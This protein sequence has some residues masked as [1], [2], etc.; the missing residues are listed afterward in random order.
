MATKQNSVNNL[1]TSGVFTTG[2]TAGNTALI[3]AYDVDGA[4]P[5]T[6]ATLTANNTPTMDLSD[7]VTKSGQY[8]YRAGGTDVPVAD[9]GL[10]VSTVPTN[11]Q[12]PIGNGTNYTVASLTAGANITIT[13]GAGTISIASTASGGTTWSEETGATIEITTGKGYVC[14]RGTLITATLPATAAIGDNFRFVGKGAGLY[15]IAQRANQY[16]NLGNTVTST[17]VGGSLATTNQFD[18]IEVVCTVTDVGFTVMSS[19]GN[20]TVV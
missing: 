7:S 9:G 17:G 11:G 12:I 13:P 2:V 15:S 18:C 6:F 5:V 16:I 20:F 10:G 4:V 8:I 3:Q 14:Y 19:I 1:S